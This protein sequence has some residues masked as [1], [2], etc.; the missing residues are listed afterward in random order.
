MLRAVGPQF[1][2]RGISR[3]NI[4]R[5]LYGV[6]GRLVDTVRNVLKHATAYSLA[7]DGWS[8]SSHGHFMV[9]NCQA[10]VPF[11]LSKR[12]ETVTLHFHRVTVLTEAGAAGVCGGDVIAKII[13]KV[14]QDFIIDDD[15]CLTSTS[16]TASDAL[17]TGRLL[18]LGNVDGS[19]AK[20]EQIKCHSHMVSLCASDNVHIIK[21]LLKRS[22]TVIKTYN[23]SASLHTTAANI[24]II[25]NPSDTLVG[26]LPLPLKKVKD[27]DGVLP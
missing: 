5:L 12:L 16:D 8:A 20:P 7:F 4:R 13:R 3:T 17:R 11:G 21:D 10:L 2:G 23:K 18:Q 24:I 15:R 19:G 14:L 1:S 25:D 26:L 9:L 6:C 22:S 27:L